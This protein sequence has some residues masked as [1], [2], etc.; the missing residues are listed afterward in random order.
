M[1][2]IGQYCFVNIS[3][4]KA[5]I[6]IKFETSIHKIVKNHQ[7]IFGK[8]LLPY[9]PYLSNFIKIGAFVKEIFAKQY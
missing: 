3:A 4:K 2:F 8:S 5:P 6:I 7:Q 9:E 1:I